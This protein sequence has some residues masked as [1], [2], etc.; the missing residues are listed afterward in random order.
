[1]SDILIW[2]VATL[3]LMIALPTLVLSFANRFLGLI[4]AIVIGGFFTIPAFLV[5]KPA[6]RAEM[7]GFIIF[8]ALSGLF[9]GRWL[10]KKAVAK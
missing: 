3:F 4:A 1:M 10:G 9:L 8:S 7:I 5:D 2:D 6:E